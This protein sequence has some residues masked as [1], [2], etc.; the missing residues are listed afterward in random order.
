MKRSLLLLL[1][2]TWVSGSLLAAN[3]TAPLLDNSW[4]K[5]NACQSGIVLLDIRSEKIDGQSKPDYMKAHIPCAVHT[6]YV[7]S[8]WREKRGDIPGMLPPISKLEALIGKLGIDN[9]T[10]VVLIPFG[11]HAKSMGS[12]TRLYW[13]FKV[14]GHDKV[15]ILNG[16]HTTYSKQKGNRL[17][18]GDY[19]Y[20]AKT[21]KARPR[22]EMI[23]SKQEVQTAITKAVPLV[24][25][26]TPDQYLGINRHPKAKKRGSIP[27]ASNLPFTW[28]TVNN[29][30]EF[31]SKDGLREAYRIKDVPLQGEQITMCNTGHLATMG[32]FVS[33]E[34][35]G[36]K[37]ARLYDGS[38]TEWSKDTE[39]SV[40]RKITVRD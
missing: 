3:N 18:T 31:R 6:D 25:N 33:S 24:D 14:L 10:H 26:R 37:Q 12:A 27:G 17:D 4:V 32:W 40:E 38:M 39:L 22:K 13:T 15:S 5:Q 21:F 19:V 36:N 35:L 9:E 1:M 28:L 7:K 23:V 30:G 16:G 11:K 34:L 8:G 2:L 20:A 29:S